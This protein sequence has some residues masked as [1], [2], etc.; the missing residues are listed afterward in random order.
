MTQE[1]WIT[2]PDWQT[3]VKHVP[4]V[5]VD[6]V[7][8]HEDAVLLAKRENEPA[9]GQ[10]FVPG[11]RVL[12]NETREEAVH[13]VAKQELGVAVDIIESIGAYEHIYETA[14]VDVENGK[15]YLANG[16]V[17]RPRENNFDLDSQHSA[18]KF[19]ESPPNE[20]HE[21]IAAYFSDAEA[22]ERWWE[23]GVKK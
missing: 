21:F 2:D 14:D 23:A 11:G 5:S 8:F 1:D 9:K 12:K 17:V 3:I 7:V 4:I 20:L 15:H 13:R 18:A 6:L 19:F 10:W 16:Y 22:L